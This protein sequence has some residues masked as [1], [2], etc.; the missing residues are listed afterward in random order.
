V[1]DSV[2]NGL[3]GRWQLVRALYQGVS[4]PDE[5][6]QRTILEISSSSYVVKFDGKTSDQGSLKF[7][8]SETMKYIVLAGEIGPN[9]GLTIRGIFQHVGNRLKICY[10]LDGIVPSE[11]TT[12]P[13][14]NRYLATYRKISIP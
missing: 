2:Q 13:T 1:I 6:I 8:S 11:F 5:I 4:A 12:S 10:G 9:E 7:G 3:E 14:E